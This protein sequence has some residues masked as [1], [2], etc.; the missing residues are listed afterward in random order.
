MR[1]Y[2]LRH[3]PSEANERGI[4]QGPESDMPLDARYIGIIKKKAEQLHYKLKDES[5][6]RI[7]SSPLH[8]ARQT[9]EIIATA[10]RKP[11]IIDSSLVEVNSGILTGSKEQLA[12]LYPD[13]LRIWLSRGD[14]DGIPRAEEGDHLQARVLF[15]L[16]QYHESASEA[17]D[18][19]VSHAGFNRCLI[20]TIKGRERTA[21][22]NHNYC[23]IHR[24]NDIFKNL[25]F[26]KL[27]LA[28]AS[29]AYYTTTFNKHYVM[30]K[31]KKASVRDMSVQSDIS[32][33][34]YSRDNTLASR[35]LFWGMRGDYAVQIL[36]YIPGTHINDKPSSAEIRR[37]I[38][39]VADLSD[40]LVNITEREVSSQDLPSLHILLQEAITGLEE[41]YLKENIRNILSNARYHSLMDE[42]QVIVDYDL[43][44][45]NIIIRPDGGISIIDLGGFCRAPIDFQ[46]A[47]LFMSF[48]LL[49]E[50]EHIDIDYLVS[51]WPNKLQKSDLFLLMQARASIGAAFFQ[52]LIAA[53]KNKDDDVQIYNNYLNALNIISTQVNAR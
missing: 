15:F 48:F 36:N 33:L 51:F 28:K 34:I 19:V 42:K 53:K 26:R 40:Q 11:V 44:R 38:N 37:I 30:K 39:R 52:K 50:S 27:S 9:A 29:D 41:S 46:P 16:E 49:D 1:L 47:S 14:L 13:Y 5:N 23:I 25:P 4:I 43:H 3:G 10:F 2:V 45:S 22:V 32:K 17:C 31:I 7:L 8:R 12:E 21:P 18:I 35:I 6:L 20:N 24:I